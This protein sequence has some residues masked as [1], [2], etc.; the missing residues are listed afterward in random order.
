MDQQDRLALKYVAG[1]LAANE[2]R[3]YDHISTTFRWLMA[4]LFTANGGATIALLNS[5]TDLVGRLPG[6]AWFAAGITFSLIMG[7]LSAFMGHR[8]MRPLTEAKAKVHQGLITGDP[9]DAEQALNKLIEKQKM[10]WKTWSPTYAGLL[11]FACFVVGILTI[12]QRL[13]R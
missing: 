13:V 2:T 10:T 1:E 11:S 12:A 7:I 8:V 4:T 3:I 6:L 5:R 9:A